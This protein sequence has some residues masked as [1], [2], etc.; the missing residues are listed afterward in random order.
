VA[1]L[2][3]F[4]LTTT[5]GKILFIIATLLPQLGA[6]FVSPVGEGC[7]NWWQNTTLNYT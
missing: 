2:H 4:R 1:L 5:G 6:T 7:H 3:N